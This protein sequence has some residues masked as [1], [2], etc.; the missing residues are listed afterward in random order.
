MPTLTRILNNQIT[1]NTIEFEKLKDS[2]L[3]GSKFNANLV[4]NSNIT[5]QGNL[6][7]SGT[8][9]TTTSTNTNIN[10]PLV[11]FNSGYT[12]S[13]T[14]D[15]GILIDRNLAALS[16][17]NY[18]GLNAAWVWREDEQSFQ[19]LLTTETGTTAG[20][21]NRTAFANVVFGNTVI[22]TI[23]GEVVDSTSTSS[24]ALVVQGGVGITANLNLGVDNNNWN[25]IAGNTYFGTTDLTYPAG[26]P[27][28]MQS[29]QTVKTF[30]ATPYHITLVD[31]G[32][33]YSASFTQNT[34]AQGSQLSIVTYQ[35]DNDI[36][37]APNSIFSMSLAS[38]NGSVVIQPVTDSLGNGEYDT[39][40]LISQGGVAIQGNLNVAGASTLNGVLIKGIYT[41]STADFDGLIIGANVDSASVDQVGTT[42]VG[43]NA[44]RAAVGANATAVGAYTAFGGAGAG[45]TLI[46]AEAGAYGSPDT[47]NTFLGYQAGAYGTDVAQSIFLGYQAGSL[48][49]TDYNVIIGSF[50]GNNN[51]YYDLNISDRGENNIVVADGTGNIRLWVDPAGTTRIVSNTIATYGD[52]ASGAFTVVGG[53]GV[54][55]NIIIGG[56]AIAISNVIAFGG[57]VGAGTSGNIYIGHQIDTASVGDFTV[58]IGHTAGNNGTGANVTIVGDNAGKYNPGDSDTL[59][60]REAGHSHTGINSTMIG[61]L[62]GKQTTGNNN[63]FFGYNAGSLVTIGNNNVILGAYDGNASAASDNIIYISDGEGNPRVYI[64]DNGSLQIIG[65]SESTNGYGALRVE[66]GVSIAKKLFVSGDT[67][68]S[69]NLSVLG[70]FNKVN[71]ITY[72]LTDPIM[73]LNTGPNGAAL[74]GSVNFD[75]GI[76]ARHWYDNSSRDAF[77]GRS[78]HNGSFEYYAIVSSETG[79]VISGT[80]GNVKSGEFH[81]ANSTQA[82]DKSGTVGAITTLGGASIARQLQVGE[83]SF[84]SGVTNSANLISSAVDAFI[85]FSPTGTGTVVISPAVEGSIN[86]MNIGQAD[87]ADGKFSNIV[88]SG[89]ATG[90]NFT[91]Q[92]SGF[93]NISPTGT[94][95]IN[96]IATGNM[97]NVYIGNATPRQAAFTAANIGQ[98]LVMQAFTANSVL[99]ISP[100]GNLSVDEQS[101]NFSYQRA[102][103]NTFSTVHLA[104]GTDGDFTGTDTLQL[105]YQG[106]SYL[107]QSDTAANTVGQ[108][109]GWTVSTSRGTVH[110]PANV[111]AGDFNGV[112]S[113]FAF[114]GATPGYKEVAGVKFTVEGTE[115]AA[116]GIGGETQIWTKQDNGDN[117][118]AVRISN[119]Q[120]ATFFGQV[121]IANSTTSTTTTEGA[122]VVQGG[123]GIGGNL[124]VSQ[125]A[126][127]NDAQNADR[128]LYVRGSNDATLLWAITAN[129]Y[130]AVLIGNSATSNDVIEG[131]KLQIFSSD[132]IRLPV[133]NDAQRPAY[134]VEGMFRYNLI[135][136]DVE[137]YDG[138]VWFA[139]RASSAG[140]VTNQQFNGDALTTDFELSR[141]ATSSSVIVSINGVLQVPGGGFS[142][143]VVANSTVGTANFGLF[144]TLSFSEAPAVGDLVDARVITLPFD[145]RG[146][147]SINDHVGFEVTD[148]DFGANV[149]T[150]YTQANTTQSWLNDGAT[151]FYGMGNLAVATSSVVVDSFGITEY[152][153]AKYYFQVS[154]PGLDEYESS[155]V[156]VV[157]DGTTAYRTQYAR[158]FTGANALGSVAV[159][160]NSGNVDVSFTGVNSGNFVK[161]RAEYVTA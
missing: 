48:T 109:A 76:R 116:N 14:Y 1:D 136:G 63:Q 86:N 53:I 135:R 82:S 126:R 58:V 28:G 16:P 31:S 106:D 23:A 134:P 59:I 123:A 24:G 36:N 125:G 129:A 145:I 98:D 159:T 33:G 47:N 41:G 69:G 27:A 34:S 10:D 42:V 120:V 11:I 60:G 93:A 37:F 61:A 138:N 101:L 81:S 132:S 141:E 95:V 62:S 25:K 40:A 118:L 3:V 108:S 94:V 90:Y 156:M 151:A 133:G 65:S 104:V 18:G 150:G 44:A 75:V 92:G 119:S 143:E 96:P 89:D 85:E 43:M 122:L 127:I 8:Y 121:A 139:A 155:E 22:K 13:P 140:I 112:F 131:A 124:N 160:I 99:F 105:H 66:G 19:T 152:R 78:D 4:L 52:S 79:N 6:T 128:D 161:T 146:I 158:I 5:V 57:T 71:A 12:G 21:I 45:T 46:G 87:P 67:T 110:A 149:F 35:A 97:D 32:A 91:M 114:T 64:D 103:A 83:Y 49:E 72:T 20:S 107:D 115:L 113:A 102:T 51:P 142:Y 77:F 9:I 144:T 100:S 137:F 88:I 55:G 84:I 153:S 56:N 29:I 130:N 50:D 148:Q 157:H 70:E 68:L 38:A 147:T 111:Q 117:T 2:T 154:N 80:Y 30:A 54:Q 15:I 39:G 73:E 17:T 74:G 7:V 26:S